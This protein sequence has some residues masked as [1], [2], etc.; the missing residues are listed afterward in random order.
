MAKYDGTFACGHKGIVEVFGPVKDR[1]W[2]INYAFSKPCD[3]CREKQLLE[4]RE[5]EALEAMERA[6]EMELPE[7]QGTEKQVSWAVRIRDELIERFNKIEQFDMEEWHKYGDF[8]DFTS[9]DVKRIKYYIL[10]TKTKASFYINNR[11]L[12]QRG[13]MESI[14]YAYKDEALKSDEEIQQD[15]MEKQLMEELKHEATVFPENKVTNAV[16]EIVVKDDV[17]EVIFEKNEDFRKLVRSLGYT[18]DGKWIK[19]IKETTGSAEE[20]AA[21]LGN[22]LLNAGFPICILDEDVRHNAI[23]GVFEPEHKRWI[24]RRV[25]IDKFAISWN[26]R[27]EDLFHLVKTLPG[28]RWDN[29]SML[30]SVAHYEAVEEFADLYDFRFTKAARKMIDEYKKSLENIEVVKP[31]KVVEKDRKDGLKEILESSDEI[32]DDLKD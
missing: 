20:R 10:K 5:R 17:V 18:W 9:D 25:D 13:S 3:E 26:R 22:K 29:P 28:A 16:V 11:H 12:I 32:I 27:E 23:H 2:K 31:T 15:L 6:K 14:L 30:V 7:L 21:E 24:Y 4:K 1:E 19:K 8:E